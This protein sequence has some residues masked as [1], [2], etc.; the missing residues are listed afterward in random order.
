MTTKISICIPT[1]DQRPEYL[2]ECVMSALAQDYTPLEV[3]I[4]DNHSIVEVS[5]VLSDIT[6]DRLRIVKPTVH[7]GSQ[8]GYENFAFCA[9]QSTGDY[10]NF[11]SSD[12][13]LAPNFCSRMAVLLDENPEI[14]F[15]HSA[16]AR[17]NA[18][19]EIY[20][21]ERSIHPS[22]VR[23][24]K[25]ELQ[26]YVWGQRNVII[27][28]LIRRS[29]YESVGGWTAPA[30]TSD[31]YLSMRLLTV[32]G[33]AYCSD[34]LAYYRDWSTPSRRQ[35]FVSQVQDTASTYTLL[36]ESNL[37]ARIEGGMDTIDKAKRQH[38]IRLAE[39]IPVNDLSTEELA[40]S[41]Q[42]IRSLND[43]IPVRVRLFL[44][45]K[46]AGPLFLAIRQ[47]QGWLR[48][49]VKSLLYPPSEKESQN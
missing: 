41:I 6:D 26:R 29:A 17:I 28:A 15:A 43:S 5:K 8:G 19:G 35:R 23:S 12:D 27:A 4:S 2:R 33:V 21:Y 31:W 9:S 49:K 37:V 18:H 11:L 16:V 40:V 3:I 34:V 20:G 46:G 38:A 36:V 47:I 44:S 39:R 14:S 32:G 13:M 42:G 24:G 25:D 22:F 10:L 7:L 30:M 48:Q 45:T 1:Y